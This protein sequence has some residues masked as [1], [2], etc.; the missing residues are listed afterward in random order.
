M[1][2]VLG[3][4]VDVK[5]I[6]HEARKRGIVSLVDGSQA[7]VHMSVNVKDIGCDFYAI[8]GHKLCGPSGSGA[9]YIKQEIQKKCDHSLVVEI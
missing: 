8:T 6:C 7:A 2:N 3:T 4:V 9:I 1:S 5:T